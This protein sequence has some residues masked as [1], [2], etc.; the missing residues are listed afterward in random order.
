MI[1]RPPRSTRTDTLFPYTTL[2]RS[3]DRVRDLF[4]RCR[5]E[6][7]KLDRNDQVIAHQQ[8]SEV[9]PRPGWRRTD[10]AEVK[11]RIEGR[12]VGIQS[13]ERTRAVRIL[14]SPHANAVAR[15]SRKRRG[16]NI[17]DLEQ[18]IGRAQV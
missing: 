6:R 18:K 13:R 5:P 1:R 10:D 15:V 4:G 3:L 8:G 2:F 12:Q 14:I 9:D 11:I 16:W 17:V 7:S